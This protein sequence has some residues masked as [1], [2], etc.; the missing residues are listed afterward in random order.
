MP[1]RWM[2]AYP[3]RSDRPLVLGHRGASADAPENTVAAFK[4]AIRQGADGIELDVM[5][6]GSGE[7]VVC[8]DSWLDRLAGA[9]VEVAT[10]PLAELQQLDLGARF[11][12]RFSGERIPTLHDA[13]KALPARAVCNVE[14]KCEQPLSDHGLA[15]TVSRE[16]R[17][18]DPGQE[19]IISS[20]NPVVLARMRLFA[21]HLPLGL[22]VDASQHVLPRLGAALALRASA[23]HVP[24]RLCT[25]EAVARWHGWGLKVAAWTVDEPADLQRCCA[26]GVDV[27][28]TNKPR[29]TLDTLD[30]LGVA[31]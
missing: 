28:I 23:I 12:A 8:H 5:R 13:L 7:L 17:R 4:E 3:I 14:L 2:Q 15:W 24:H 30:Q 16:L 27:L 26:A 1:A 25:R 29:A 11:G 18:A 19:L 9:H 10:T 21:A 20:F 6:C 22:L 31:D